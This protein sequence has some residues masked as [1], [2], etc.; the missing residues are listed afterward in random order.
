MGHP[1]SAAEIENRT[2]LG[3]AP[4]LLPSVGPSVGAG[5]AAHDGSRLAGPGVARPRP[6]A[7]PRIRPRPLTRTRPRPRTRTRPHPRTGTRPRGAAHLGRPGR[8]RR[9]RDGSEAPPVHPSIFVE[10]DRSWPRPPRAGPSGQSSRLDRGRG[11]GTSRVQVWRGSLR[12][13]CAVLASAACLGR[14]REQYSAP[15]EH[16]CPSLFPFVDSPPCSPPAPHPTRTVPPGRPDRRLPPWAPET[17]RATPP[18]PA[19]ARA[20]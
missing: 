4:P 6:R 19:R 17:G 1:T 7:L 14:R 10:P 3:P 16:D 20:P 13:G 18:R 12:P 15:C 8:S 2:G 5:A 11:P 9:G